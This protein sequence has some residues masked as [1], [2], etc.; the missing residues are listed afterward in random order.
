MAEAQGVWMGPKEAGEGVWV[1]QKGFLGAQ[2]LMVHFSLLMCS[3][4]MCSLL[5]WPP[6]G[7]QGKAAS[8]LFDVLFQ[9]FVFSKI[10]LIDTNR[11]K[12]AESCYI[13]NNY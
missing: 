6:E 8:S 13:G 10:L 7:S 3:G 9:G 11:Q 5:K 2:M 4:F 1:P 12:S